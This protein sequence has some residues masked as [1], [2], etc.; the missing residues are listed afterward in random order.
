MVKQD[1]DHFQTGQP[2]CQIKTQAVSAGI[3][4]YTEEIPGLLDFAAS[5]HSILSLHGI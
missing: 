5:I 1:F 4:I 2:L 3:R